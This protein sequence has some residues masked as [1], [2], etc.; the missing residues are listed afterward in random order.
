MATTQRRWIGL[1]IV[2]AAVAIFLPLHLTGFCFSE[3]R[4]IG[5]DEFIEQALLYRAASIKGLPTPV[6]LEDVRTYRRANPKCCRVEG[7]AFPL[8]STF[9]D[10]LFGTKTTWVRI[11]HQLTEEKAASYKGDTYYEAYIALDRCGRPFRTSGQSLSETEAKQQ[12]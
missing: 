12:M 5:E 1:I 8:N 2:V 6:T 10:R 9:A 11:V 7:P 4:Y 3:M